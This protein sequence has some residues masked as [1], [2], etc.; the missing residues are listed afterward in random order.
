MALGHNERTGGATMLSVRMTTDEKG[1][2]NAIVAKRCTKDTP[3]AKMVTKAD[4]MPALDK[5]GNHV[6]RL[7]FD[8]IE[9]RITKLEKRESPFGEFLDVTIEDGERY[10]LSMERGDR[11]WGDFLQRLLNVDLSASVKLTPYSIEEDG[12]YNQGIAM[13]QYGAKIERKWNSANGYEGGPPQAEY[14]DFEKQWRFGKRNAWLEKNVL[15]VVCEKLANGSLVAP[16]TT[17]APVDED[18]LPF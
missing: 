16:V 9:G 7:E 1:R 2:K 10:V 3:G 17:A 6:F 12:K 4:G 11:Y 13:R 18:D 15:E 14:D 8:F 5:E